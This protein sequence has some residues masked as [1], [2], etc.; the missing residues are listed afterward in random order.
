MGPPCPPPSP[1]R[2]CATAMAR[3]PPSTASTSRSARGECF[4]LLGPNGAGKTTTRRD[5]RGAAR[6]RRAGDGRGARAALG[7]TTPTPCGTASASRCRRRSSP[8]GSPSKRRCGCSARF[9]DRGPS[10]AELLALRAARGEARRLGD[11]P[12]RR[13]AAAAGGGAARWSAIPSSCSSTSRPPASTRSRAAQLWDIDRGLQ[14]RRRAP[15]CSPPTTWTRPSGSATA[16]RSIDHGKVIA[17]GTPRRAHRVARRRHSWCELGDGRRLLPAESPATASPAVRSVRRDADG[18]TPRRST[19]RTSRCP[20]HRSRASPRTARSS[21]QL[22]TRS[23]TL[24]D[25]FVSL[26]GRS[27]RED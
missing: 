18:L 23:A 21:T 11:A 16:W 17:L 24:E 19:S 25:V 2:A 27:L 7:P 14:G 3:S 15:S 1:S 12:L 13:A 8:T 10:V 6:A 9:Y 4:G 20:A 26:T 5:P 22:A